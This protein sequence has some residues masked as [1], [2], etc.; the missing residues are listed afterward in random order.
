M[1]RDNTGD[2]ESVALED[3]EELYSFWLE[4]FSD[5][6][7]A[8]SDA[9]HFPVLIL[10]DSPSRRRLVPHFVTVNADEASAGERSIKIWQV[11]FLLF[12]VFLMILA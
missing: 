1:E 9:I 11:C 3:D 7:S 2:D 10:E 4:L 5:A 6:T 8:Q 12:L